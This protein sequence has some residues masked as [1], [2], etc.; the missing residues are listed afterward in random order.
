M[1]KLNPETPDL[2]LAQIERLRE[3]FPEC[4]TE[5]PDGLAVDFD[6]LKQ[7]LS[8][9]IVEGP[10]ERY[11]LDWP[12]KREAA[13][14]AN[15]PTDKT[16]RPARDESVDFDTTQNLFIEGDNLEALKIIQETYLGQVK[17]IYIDPPYN[18]G[19]D[20][21]YRDNFTQDREDYE[22]DS[23]QRDEDG[24]RLVANPETSGRFHSDWLSMMYPRLK[25]AKNLLADDGVIFISIDDGEVANLRRLCDEVFGAGNFV[26]QIVVENDSRARPY[27]S[28]ASTHEYLLVYARCDDFIFEELYDDNKEFRFSDDQG[29]YDLYELRNRN[30]AFNSDNRPNLFY[31]FWVNP[32]PIDGSDLHEISLGPKEGYVEVE[33]QKSQ[34][35][36]TVWRWGKETASK[37]LNTVLF[38]KKASNDF[39]YQ[40]VKKYRETSRTLNSV[41][42]DKDIKTDKGTLETKKLFENKKYFDFPKPTNLLRRLLEIGSYADG[43]ILDFFAGS[44]TTAH[45]VMQ[46][47][48]EDGGN[49]RFIMVQLPEICD[50]KSEAAKAGYATIAEISKE[51]IRRAGQK[52]LEGECHDDWNKDIGFRVLK[53][54][55]SNLN[56]VRQTPDAASQESLLDAVENIKPDRSEEDLLFGVML[57]WGVD[58]AAPVERREIDGKTVFL[59]NEDDL[60][61]CFDPSVTEDFVKRLTDLKPLKIVFRDDAFASDDV[62]INTVQIFKQ[63]SPDTEVRSI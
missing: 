12:G 45:A 60:V 57:R 14:M 22:E 36:Q 26:N 7:A 55:E 58:L 50:E 19:N 8:S 56:A 1:E 35:I 18:T 32:H 25:L 5:G 44:A 30:V 27:G 15:Q 53:I 33:P 10:Q 3:L 2:A 42:V 59:V 4:V 46:L 40:I 41:W 37:N 52:I 28:V 63:A 17:M 16:L 62:K 61:A 47:N 23:G 31:S 49:R 9:Q 43:L 20:F 51:R 6:A 13:A 11:R 29:G 39:G 54:D 21:V 34:G 48:A 24:N 38:A